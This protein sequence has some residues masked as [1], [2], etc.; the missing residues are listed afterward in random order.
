MGLQALGREGEKS[1]LCL[2]RPSESPLNFQ[3]VCRGW[4]ANTTPSILQKVRGL[5]GGVEELY[6]T[7]SPKGPGRVLSLS[8][9]LG[10]PLP[11]SDP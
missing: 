4:P 7:L 9:S 3:A 8:S 5:S 10:E 11:V 6:P 1:T 2:E